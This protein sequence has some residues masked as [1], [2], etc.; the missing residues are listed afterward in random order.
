MRFA[1]IHHKQIELERVV[2]SFTS[3]T[4]ASEIQQRLK[5][6]MGPSSK[7]Q[8]GLAPLPMIKN[9]QGRPC[10]TG[11]AAIERWIQFFSEMEGGTR[12]SLSEQRGLWLSNLRQ[13][14]Q[15]TLDVPINAL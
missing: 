14:Q 9:D 8:Q 11:L 12:V 2:E 15:W 13:L 4:A 3:A 10:T 7:T 6:F 5:P 1:I